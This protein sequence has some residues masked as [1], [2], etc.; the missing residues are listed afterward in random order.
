MWTWFEQLSQWH[1]FIFGLFLL[2]GEALG[3]SGFLLGTAIA[4]LLMGVIVWI[5]ATVS[6]VGLSWQIQVLV[7][8]LLSV[9]FSILYWRFFRAEQQATDRPNLNHRSAQL[10]GRKLVLEKDIQFEGRIQIG[11]TFWKVVT[12]KPLF[13]GEPV[14]VISADATT[15]TLRK[16]DS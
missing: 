13:M 2:M 1:W 4:S 15:L 11:D 9:T 5:V 16:L 14:E 10:V 8:A 6:D 3:A 12:D 7:G